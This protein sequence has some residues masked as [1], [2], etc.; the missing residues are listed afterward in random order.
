MYKLSKEKV[1]N[2]LTSAADKLEEFHLNRAESKIE[3][4]LI[5]ESMYEIAYALKTGIDRADVNECIDSVCT[6]KNE[7][8]G[9]LRSNLKKEILLKTAKGLHANAKVLEKLAKTL[10]STEDVQ[11]MEKDTPTADCNSSRKTV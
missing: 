10:E 4:Q 11:E 1:N 5:A 3:K 7:L 9:L 6:C 2:W 8:E